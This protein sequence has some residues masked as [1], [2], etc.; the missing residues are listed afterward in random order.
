MA[1]TKRALICGVSG[2]DG[3]YLAHHLLH[4]GYEV[5]GTSRDAATASFLNLERLEI[6]KEVQLVSLNVRDTGQAFRLF[7]QVRPDEV[8]GLAAQSSVGLSFAQPVETIESIVLG[9]VS[10]LEA[11][12]LAALGIRVYNAGSTE[13]FGDTGH[14]VADES[15]PFVPRS[16]YAV[17]MAA[18]YWTVVNYRDAYK[19]YAC[20]G[21]LSNHDSPLRPARFVSRK[22]V[23]AA[24]E[25]A[26]GI[27]QRLTL[28][29]LDIERDWGWAPDYVEA[30]WRM[31]QPSEPDDFVIAT[32]CSYTLREFVE[33]AFRYIGRNWEDYVDIDRDLFRPADIGHSKVNPAKAH[34]MLGWKATRT[35]PG[36]VQCMIEEEL[37]ALRIAPPAGQQ[38]ERSGS[39]LL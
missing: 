21:I 16:P 28:G 9:T 15:S 6:R 25:I 17:G 30:M 7:R 11:I 22:I 23:R 32:G 36:I 5:W 14:R 39:Q 24:A 34:R 35:M 33:A 26:R 19:L 31:L 10:L 12:R 18:S 1:V 29:N 20:T 3:A 2:Q 8:Y 37:S 38:A 27:S 4:R 13:C